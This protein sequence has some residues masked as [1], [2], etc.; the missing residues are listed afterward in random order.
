MHNKN[1]DTP[2]CM[3]DLQF[4]FDDDR[5]CMQSHEFKTDFSFRTNLTH[6]NRK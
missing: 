4:H 2:G 1:I 6:H 3:P 5:L